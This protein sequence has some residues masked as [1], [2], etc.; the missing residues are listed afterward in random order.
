MNGQIIPVSEAKIS[1][2][3]CGL[4]RSFIT[5]DVIHLCEDAFFHVDCYLN[6]FEVPMKKNAS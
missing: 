6:P 5:Y 4:T 1:V 3:N 2:F